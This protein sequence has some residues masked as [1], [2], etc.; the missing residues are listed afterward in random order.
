MVVEVKAGLD[1]LSVE[2]AATLAMLRS[3]GL[4]T[5]T[6][7]EETGLRPHS[8]VPTEHSVGSLLVQIDELHA[9]LRLVIAERDRLSV[10][11]SA[12]RA[13]SEAL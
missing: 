12:H 9:A 10:E 2:Q 11:L 5:F 3:F 6:W 13:T 1:W 4:P 8:A 7:T